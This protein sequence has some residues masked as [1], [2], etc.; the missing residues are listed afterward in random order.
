MSSAP[1]SSRMS[2][3]ADVSRGEALAVIGALT[4]SVLVVF[5]AFLSAVAVALSGQSLLV[6]SGLLGQGDL[7]LNVA[8]SALQFV[9]FGVGIGMYL[10]LSDRFDLLQ[11]RTPTLTDLG[12]VVGG[13]VAIL[14]AAAVVGNVLDQLGVS[15]AQNQVILQ[16]QEQPVF[17][18]YMIPVSLLFVGPFEELVFRGTVQELLRDA[19]GPAPAIA[20]ASAMFGIVHWIALTGG[21]SRLSYIAVAATLG[22][23]LGYVYEKS[24][25]LVVPALVHGVYNSVL[26]TIQ[27]AAA[28]GLVNM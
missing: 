21:G 16:G 11:I 23:V 9:G 26:F 20:V 15:V 27:Y 5:V 12:W 7:L 13:L 14:L 22:L 3:D 6:S 24:R 1:Q 18:L 8:V 19:V 28:T 25:N 4:Q 2:V 10:Y 17:F